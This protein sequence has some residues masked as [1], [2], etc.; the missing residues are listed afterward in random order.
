MHVDSAVLTVMDLIVPYNRIAVCADLKLVVFVTI[1][2]K[3]L[4]FILNAKDFITAFVKIKD[5]ISNL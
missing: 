3:R 4:G 2:C 1:Y 5:V